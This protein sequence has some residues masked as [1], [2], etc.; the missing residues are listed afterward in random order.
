VRGGVEVTASRAF[1]LVL[2]VLVGGV[3]AVAGALKLRA[4]G[5]FATEIANYQLTPAAAPYLAVTLPV[6]ELML[7]GALIVAPRAWRR[8]A[9]LGALALFGM[10]TGAVASAYFRR[11][12]IDCGCF[13]TGGGPITALTLA[14]NV[15][16]MTAA[17]LVLRFDRH[18]E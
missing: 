14:R 3:L 11:I 7:G 12:N 1:A 15:G 5:A 16:L 9:A 10:F 17:A 4:P 6:V 13:G 2:R 8:A 18:S